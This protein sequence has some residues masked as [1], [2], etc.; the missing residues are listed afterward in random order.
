MKTGKTGLTVHFTAALSKEATSEIL[1]QKIKIQS[2]T[3]T[4]SQRYGSGENEKWTNEIKS[5]TVS[6]DQKSVTLGMP[7]FADPAMV[8]DR[9]YQ[10]LISDAKA[11]F[12]AT[13]CRPELEAYQTIRAVPQ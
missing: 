6:A 9:I 1:Q 10:I 11:L 4:D 5:V 12:G 3:Y 7:V 2:W 8:T 13:P